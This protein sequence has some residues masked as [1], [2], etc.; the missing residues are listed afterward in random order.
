METFEEM[1]QR[2]Q[3]DMMRYARKAVPEKKTPEPEPTVVPVSAPAPAAVP[4]DTAPDRLEGDN[5]TATLIV[6]TTTAGEALPLEGTLVI[7]SR[8]IGDR[9]TLQWMGLTDISGST[10]RILLPAPDKGRSEQPGEPRPYASYI[11]QA[12]R[13][14]YYTAEFRNVPVFADVTAVQPVEMIPLPVQGGSV[15]EKIVIERAPDL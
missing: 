7:I 5:G 3:N 2:Y 10:D 9:P 8:Y 13:E 15:P 12:V 11:I 6:R 1:K 4:S 14:G